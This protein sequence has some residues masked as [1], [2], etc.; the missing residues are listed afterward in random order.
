MEPLYRNFPHAKTKYDL[1]NFKR[2]RQPFD[3]LSVLTANIVAIQ[4]SMK[5]EVKY[6]LET[7][8][9]QTAPGMG[10]VSAMAIKTFAPSLE[11]FM[12]GHDFAT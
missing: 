11:G 5:E 7:I 4:P 10:P 12:R 1:P 3:Q 2:S 9:L 6:D 8:G